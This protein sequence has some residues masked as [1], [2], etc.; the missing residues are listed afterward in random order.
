MTALTFD[1]VAGARSIEVELDEVGAS[2]VAVASG[3]SDVVFV[4]VRVGRVVQSPTMWG[5][6][7]GQRGNGFSR[8]ID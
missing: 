5:V 7:G 6:G 4:V 8:F 3:D 2:R 1:Y